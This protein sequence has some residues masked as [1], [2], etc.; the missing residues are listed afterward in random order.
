MAE[1]IKRKRNFTTRFLAIH[2]HIK[3]AIMQIYKLSGNK[4]GSAEKCQEKENT[5]VSVVPCAII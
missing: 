4:N 1:T 3:F 5:C 2:P